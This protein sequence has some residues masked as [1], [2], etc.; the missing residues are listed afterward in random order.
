MSV[1]CG[2]GLRKTLAEAEATPQ[3]TAVVGT[4]LGHWLA[5]ECSRGHHNPFDLSPLYP[6]YFLPKIDVTQSEIHLYISIHLSGEFDFY[7]GVKK[8]HTNE[9][10]GLCM[11]KL[12]LMSS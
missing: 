9:D 2:V 1:K 6:S 3:F 11:P 12:V 10:D 7:L 5:G 4:Q 8:I